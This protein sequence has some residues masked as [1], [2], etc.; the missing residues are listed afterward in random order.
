M[1]EDECSKQEIEPRDF[2]FTRREVRDFTAWGNTQL[3][4]HMARLLE[5]EYLHL[6]KGSLGQSFI[7][8]LLYKGEGN[9]GQSF[10]M[11]LIN[12][13]T[14]SSGRGKMAGGRPLVGGWSGQ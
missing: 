2:R 7:Y 10:V 8:Q 1:S 9:A 6:W 14:I 4:V 11:N 3:K 5:M 13:S 12:T